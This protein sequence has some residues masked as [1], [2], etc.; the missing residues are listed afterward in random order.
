MFNKRNNIGLTPTP[1]E[2]KRRRKNTRRTLIVVGGIVAVGAGAY[3]GSKKSTEAI[4]ETLKRSESHLET[5][6]R[7]IKF[8]E[9]RRSEHI[10]AIDEALDAGINFTHFPGLGV[11]SFEWDKVPTKAVET[12][13]KKKSKK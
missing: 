3:F 8:S 1:K 2:V 12:V 9:D 7:F 10:K 13:S 5:I 6:R 4:L 11:H